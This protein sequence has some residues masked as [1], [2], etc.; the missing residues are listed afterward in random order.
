MKFKH[1]LMGILLA[2]ILLLGF[3]LERQSEGCKSCRMYE[4]HLNFTKG[5]L[6]EGNLKGYYNYGDYFCV[7]IKD[8]EL[9]SIERTKLHEWSHDFVFN[10]YEHFCIE[11]KRKA[12]D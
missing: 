9:T 3:L 8:R 7:W 1:L 6:A 10:D 5:E 2:N 11:P 12:K 4:Y